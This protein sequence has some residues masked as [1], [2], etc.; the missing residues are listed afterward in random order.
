MLDAITV[1]ADKVPLTET[2]LII[3][4]L[5]DKVP[6]IDKL[7]INALAIEA[8]QDTLRFVGAIPEIFKVPA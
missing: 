4:V 3:P 5:A 6:L 1:E 7:P 8:C 2:S